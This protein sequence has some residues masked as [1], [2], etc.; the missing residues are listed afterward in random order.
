MDYQTQQELS[1]KTDNWKVEEL[2]WKVDNLSRE[3]IDMQDRLRR[4]ENSISILQE[5]L[6]QTLQTFTEAE[7]FVSL[8]SLQSILNTI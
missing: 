3:N 7:H 5:S 4:Q 6:R 8:D 1:R 2:Q